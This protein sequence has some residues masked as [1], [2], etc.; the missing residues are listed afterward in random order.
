MDLADALGGE[1]AAR[2]PDLV[3]SGVV[4]LVRCGD[5]WRYVFRYARHALHH[6]VVAYAHPL[7]Y[8]R[9]AA[10]DHPVAY[11]YLAAER[12][13]VD[14]DVVVTD[15]T[16]VRDV[17]VCHYEVVRADDGLALRGGAAADGDIFAD[18][19][20]VAYFGCG[21][22]ALELH[23]LR[24]ACY[25]CGH[26]DFASLAYAGAVIYCG[27]RPDPAVVA[28]D[29]VAGDVCEGFYRDVVP[30]LGV[31][32]HVCQFADHALLFR[33]FVSHNL[34]H[35]G[36]LAGQ[37]AAYEDLAYDRGDAAAHRFDDVRFDLHRISRNDLVLET[38]VVNAQEVCRV[39]L[40]VLDALEDDDAA[41]LSHGLHEQHARHDG[42]GGEVARELRLVG[43]DVLDGADGV[44]VQI[45][46]LVHQKEG[47]AVGQQ[48][49]H[50][51]HIQQRGF[52]GTVAEGGLLAVAA[53]GMYE[54]LHEFGVG[55]VAR[56]RSPHAALDAHAEQGEVA[57]QVEQLVASELAAAGCSG[58]RP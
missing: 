58:N 29:Y 25:R 55:V 2:E 54:L 4:V 20:I 44:V 45:E 11:M 35:N 37:N 24:R 19:V 8:G 26:V 34:C 14:D 16:V 31:G 48:F 10:Y 28:Y 3:D 40:G 22:L 18:L 5:E 41:G 1:A 23:V 9:M 30:D 52:V 33:F 43:R 12:Y 32:M 47:I 21:D 56:A 39:L 17:C 13:A 7:V 6:G 42:L 38:H 50:L 36:S 53:Y 46:D 15:D 57:E 49:A 51:V 27:R